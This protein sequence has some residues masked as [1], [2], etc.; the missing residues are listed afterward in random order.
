M[1][2]HKAWAETESRAPGRRGS[3]PACGEHSSSCLEHGVTHETLPVLVR[4]TIPV[5]ELC[6]VLPALSLY[7]R[8]FLS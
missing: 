8:A 7:S 6:R 1:Y 4:V 5:F 2:W 3:R